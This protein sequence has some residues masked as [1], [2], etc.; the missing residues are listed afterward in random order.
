KALTL[1]QPWGTLVRARAKPWEFR[2]WRPPNSVI[3]ARIGIHAGARP[4][5]RPEIEDLLERLTSGTG[6]AWSTALIPEIAIPILERALADPRSMPL[7]SMLCSAVVGEP[8]EGWKIAEELGGP[9]N[10]SDREEHSNWGWPMLDVEPYE[11]I[12]PCRGMQG[13]WEWNGHG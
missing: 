5:K 10:D 1:W 2:G 8:K 9:V 13:L 7:S 12:I 3:G 11:P 6:G 4:V